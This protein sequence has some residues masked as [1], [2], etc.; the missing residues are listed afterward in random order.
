[1]KN[2]YDYSLASIYNNLND[3]EKYKKEIDYLSNL[4]SENSRILDVGCGTGIHNYILSSL[5]H[6]CVGID[7]SKQ[8]I[9]VA[10]ANN[11]TDARFI[12]V[13]AE[14]FIDDKRFDL[15]ISLFNVI[16]HVIEI[17]KLKTFFEKVAQ[18]LKK[19]G[20][21]VFDCFNSVAVIKSRPLVKDKSGFTITP[22]YN[23][24]NGILKMEYAGTS[25]FTL[26]HRIW[27]ISLLVEML[28]SVGFEV[29]FYK[30][31]TFQELSE[32][33]YKITFICRR[34]K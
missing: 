5:G 1:M 33:D 24:Y 13:S 6:D 3:I 17:E 23:P 34:I 10:N 18:N 11:K 28:E 29:E 8:M 32:S 15:C 12:N 4:I 9:E 19:N 22:E 20:L 30:R 14:E 21:F 7:I 27:D 16:N 2:E 25:N 31:N 26:T